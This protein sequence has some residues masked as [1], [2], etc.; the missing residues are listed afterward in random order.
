[1]KKHFLFVIPVLTFCGSL[2]PAGAPP[3]KAAYLGGTAGLTPNIKGT[4]NPADSGAVIFEYK[5]GTLTIPREKIS[6]LSYGEVRPNLTW[7]EFS[8]EVKFKP[9]ALGVKARHHYLTI[10]FNDAEGKDQSAVFDLTGG[11]VR[12]TIEALEAYVG[13]QA[14]CEDQFACKTLKRKAK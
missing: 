12:E 8:K 3:G 9:F 1:M 5:G 10:E 13:K 7:K 6:R 11:N 14:V 4:F 2:V